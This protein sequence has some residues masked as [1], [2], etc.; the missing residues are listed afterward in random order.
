MIR[1]CICDDEQLHSSKLEKIIM[2]SAGLYQNIELDIDIYESGKSLLNALKARNEEY[3]ILFL[4]I[5]MGILNGIEVARKL[6]K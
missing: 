6:E 5:E 1:I 3:Q 4:D 2:D